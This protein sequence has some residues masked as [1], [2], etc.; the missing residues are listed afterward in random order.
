LLYPEKT[1]KV[2]SI[3]TFT[4]P[5]IAPVIKTETPVA[6]RS[7]T[8]AFA[9]DTMFD[10]AVNH[11][12][13]QDLK[14]IFRDFD[15]SIFKK[16]NISFLNLEGPI[17]PEPIDDN[18]EPDNLIFNFPPQ[19]PDA[20]KF[21][22]IGAVSLAN[23]HTLNAGAAGFA[24]TKEILD[25]N[26]IKYVG[27]ADKVDENSIL[28]FDGEIPA[29]IIGANCLSSCAGVGKL[30]E[31]EK[32]AG[33]FVIV[34]PHWGNEYQEKHNGV[35][36]NFAHQWIDAGA[37]LVVGSHPHVTQDFEIYKN[38]P[39]VY[40]LGNFVF[41]QT[42]SKETQEGLILTGVI[43]DKSLELSFL[44]IKSVYL[45]PQLMESDQKIEKIETVLDI[46]SQNGFTKAESDTIRISR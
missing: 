32:S 5:A 44:P 26:S 42:F 20:L 18:I 24:A 14:T 41:D 33:R 40:S 21:I 28:K 1:F 30:V 17:S 36:A 25:K 35:Q 16:S 43:R 9:G 12:F 3:L 29:S 11:Y 6:E 19:T 13:K 46:D 7:V 27:S 15:S 34:F 4:N 8:F 38:K 31:Q 22:N 45:R 23:N 37:D 2:E 39:I 10:R